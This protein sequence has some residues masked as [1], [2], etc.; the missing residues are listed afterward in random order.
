MGCATCS[1]T[2]KVNDQNSTR[3]RGHCDREG[4]PI[5][6]ITGDPSF[7]IHNI[8]YALNFAKVGKYTQPVTNT[9]HLG[10]WQSRVRCR[11]RVRSICTLQLQNPTR[12]DWIICCSISIFLRCDVRQST[13]EKWVSLSLSLLKTFSVAS[14]LASSFLQHGPTSMPFFPLRFSLTGDCAQWGHWLSLWCNTITAGSCPWI[15]S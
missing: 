6:E 10:Y 8:A 2:F 3:S 11:M 1:S 12:A 4:R 5:C 13:L 15:F 9:P 7:L 14:P